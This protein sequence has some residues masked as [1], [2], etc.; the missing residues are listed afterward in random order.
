[1]RKIT[2]EW[3]DPWTGEFCAGFRATYTPERAL[4]GFY[5]NQNNAFMKIAKRWTG[6]RDPVLKVSGCWEAE[7]N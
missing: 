4:N 1:M 2:V 3:F 5:R 7:V 6:Y